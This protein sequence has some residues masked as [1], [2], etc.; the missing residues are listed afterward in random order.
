MITIS[1]EQKALFVEIAELAS[2]VHV[3]NQRLRAENQ[4]LRGTIE[5]LRNGQ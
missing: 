2:R 1:E 3:E 5:D 4:R